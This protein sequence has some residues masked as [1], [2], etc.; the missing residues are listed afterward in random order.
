MGWAS[1]LSPSKFK[2]QKLETGAAPAPDNMQRLLIIITNGA[3]LAL[4]L[5]GVPAVA[6]LRL[7]NWEIS[8]VPVAQT[9]MF[10]G[11]TLAAAG[12]GFAALIVIKGRKDRKLCWDWTAVF[13]VLLGV[14]CAFVR[15]WFNFEW[16]QR[17]LLWLQKHF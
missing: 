3:L 2:K 17:A 11:L 16:L 7:W 9:L 13:V 12:N 1:S 8:S 10:W 14:E 4:L 6:G 15:G 5:I